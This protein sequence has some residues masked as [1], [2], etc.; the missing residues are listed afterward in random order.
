[1]STGRSGGPYRVLFTPV[2]QGQL[3]GLSRRERTTLD[4]ELKD[5]AQLAGLRQW[6]SPEEC[7]EPIRFWVGR[8]EVT[9][10]LEPS[11][12]TLHVTALRGPAR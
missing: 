8:Y 10:Q 4:R 11:A 1:L 9:Y 3:P 12:R 5:L 6:L 2:A 7:Q